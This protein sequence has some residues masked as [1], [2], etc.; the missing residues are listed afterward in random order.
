MNRAAG[1]IGL[2]EVKETHNKTPPTGTRCLRKNEKLKQAEGQ[3]RPSEAVLRGEG[4]GGTGKGKGKRESAQP[5]IVNGRFCVG[6]EGS[7]E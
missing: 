2:K 6:A 5:V 7:K 4:I 1:R 3:G